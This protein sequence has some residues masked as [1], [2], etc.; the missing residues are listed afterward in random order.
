MSIAKSSFLFATGTI[1]SR[2]F[3]LLRESITAGVFGASALMDAFLVA[4]RIP[5]MLR[6]LVA[7]GAL[8]SSFIKVYS[9]LSVEDAVRAKKVLGDCLVFFSIIL[10]VVCTL[11]IIF[12]PQIVSSMTMFTETQAKG[13]FFAHTVGLTQLLFP[14]IGFMTVGAIAQGVLHQRGRFFFSAVSPII[15]N[16]G[17]IAGALAIGPLLE[18]FAPP[19]M[20]QWIAPRAMVGLALGVLLGGFLQSLMQLFVIWKP[21][22]SGYRF[23]LR[24][25]FKVSKDL[26]SVLWL[27]GPMIIA[28]SAGQ[29]NVF[30]N[31]NFATTLEE[32]AVAWLTFAFRVLQLPVGV[33]AVAV[34][35]AALPT[36]SRSIA[37]AHLG[38]KNDVA[39]QLQVCLELVTWLMIPCLAFLLTNSRSIVELLYQHW[40]FGLKATEATS[41]A[42]FCYSFSLL[43]YGWIKVLTAYYYAVERTKYAMRVSLLGIGINVLLNYYLVHQFGYQ[44]LAIGSSA[45]LVFNAMLLMLGLRKDRLAFDHKALAHSA[46]LLTAACAL[47]LVA[48]KFARIGLEVLL[49]PLNWHL[50][51][52]ATVMLACNGTI[53]ALIFGIFITLKMRKNPRALFQHYLAK[54]LRK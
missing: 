7:E 45:L 8:G 3:G 4:N 12:S 2:V 21:A 10:T 44:G 19:A 42:L 11:G 23:R 5:N 24:D 43:G 6:E 17:C 50:K 26:R 27:M 14:F 38:Q 41:N 52:K 22:L 33:I 29:I 53:T 1:L 30:V 31:T 51:F 18:T 36:L 39:K 35:A 13:S 54:R 48:Q 28:S 25:S 37:Q 20:D 40:Q 32:G 16:L 34:G 15:F 49:V 9:A 47:A 46:I